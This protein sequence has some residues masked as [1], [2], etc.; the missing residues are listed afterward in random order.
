VFV[1]TAEKIAL[2]EA[3][4]LGFQRIECGAFVLTE[5]WA[6]GGEYVFRGI[7]GLG[8]GLCR[9]DRIEGRRART[10]PPRGKW[11]FVMSASETTIAHNMGMLMPPR[12]MRCAKWSALTVERVLINA[13]WR[14][15]SDV[16]LKGPEKKKSCGS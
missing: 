2:I 5:G 7:I 4:A 14:P 13:R 1:E 9:A 15:H 10:R 12:S 6:R 8:D 16:R 3:S 11:N